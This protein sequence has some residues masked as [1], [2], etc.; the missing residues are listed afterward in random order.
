MWI[1]RL[2]SGI[3]RYVFARFHA[4]CGS[5]HLLWH[6]LGPDVA[7][8]KTEIG[9]LLQLERFSGSAKFPNSP[10]FYK[11]NKWLVSSNIIY[12]VGLKFRI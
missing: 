5:H 10:K 12:T 4:N 7:Q 1:S 9:P 3:R 2:F 11:K 6:K 8:V